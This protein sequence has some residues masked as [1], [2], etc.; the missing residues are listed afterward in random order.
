MLLLDTH[1]FI[2]LASDLDKLSDTA[3]DAIDRD[4]DSLFI[5]GI[6]GLEIALA[7]KRQRLILPVEPDVFVHKAMLQHGVRQIPVTVEIGCRAAALPDKHNDPF[8]RI[9]LA[10][11]DRH[12]MTIISKDSLFAKYPD[13]TVIW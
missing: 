10:T 3:K 4:G 5:S 12:G 9:I 11:A 8:D 6:T 2:W 13:I 7:A 1:A